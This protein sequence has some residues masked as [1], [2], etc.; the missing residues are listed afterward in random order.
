MTPDKPIRIQRKR[1]PGF[2]M[3]EVSRAING[4][5][6]RYVGRPGKFANSFIVGECWARR[7]MSPGGGQISGFVLNADVAAHLYRTYTARETWF[8]ESVHELR[9]F[10]LA[11]WC[12][13]LNEDGS[14]H[15]CHADIPLSIANDIPLKQVIENN[16]RIA[17]ED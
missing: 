9:G 16:I 13:I 11:C 4:R 7:K 14:Y 15:S 1:R 6:C 8:L 12:S 10:N 17:N 5:D 3:Q 2:N